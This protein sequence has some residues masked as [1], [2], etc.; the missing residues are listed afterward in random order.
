[1]P[2]NMRNDNEC[3]SC[4]GRLTLSGLCPRC[5]LEPNDPPQLEENE[6]L[7]SSDVPSAGAKIRYF[8]EYELLKEIGQSGG[9]GLVYRARQSTTGRIVALKLL[10]PECLRSEELVQRFRIEVKAAIELDH[11][12]IVPIYEIGENRGQHYYTMK[13]VEEGS[14]AEQMEE[15]KWKLVE[16]GSLAEQ[17]DEGKWNLTSPQRQREL[18]QL[19]EQVARGVS[20]AHVHGVLHRDLKPG[21]ILIDAAG[22]PYVA[23][24]GL[25]KFLDRETTATKKNKDVLGSPGYMSPEQADGKL[26]SVTTASDVYSLGVILY[27]LL[28]G[29][30]PF[31]GE[32]LETLRKVREETPVTPRSLNPL[33]NPDLQAICLKCLEKDTRDRFATAQDLAN[34][35]RRFVK[36][37]PITTR[38]PTAWKRLLMWYRREPVVAGLATATAAIFLTGFLLTLWQWSR[39][40]KLA[41][42]ESHA[43]SKAENALAIVNMKT[44]E[45]L[46][47]SG[48]DD[49]AIAI[50]SDLV[51]RD[52][53]N[54]MAA[55]RLLWALNDRPSLCLPLAILKHNDQPRWPVPVSHD[56]R[57]NTPPL[58]VETN[59][60][61]AQTITWTDG[62]AGIRTDVDAKAA[63]KM[64]DVVRLPRVLGT[65]QSPVSKS[66]NP[67]FTGSPVSDPEDGLN[68]VIVAFSSDGGRFAS[69]SG[70]TTVRVWDVK[71]GEPLAGPLVHQG[72]VRALEFSA[73]GQRLLTTSDQDPQSLREI[74]KENSVQVWDVL[75]G[76]LLNHR[77]NVTTASFSPDGR[78]VLTVSG[79]AARV[80]DPETGQD[81]VE[82][83]RHDSNV[84][85]AAF[86]PDGQ[87]IATGSDDATARIWNV[88]T[89]Q[90]LSSPIQ[91]DSKSS[92]WLVA[93][94][95]DS[96]RLVTIANEAARVWE[97]GTGRP[98]T[99]PLEHND[100]VE[101][102]SFSPDGTGV[103]TLTRHTGAVDDEIGVHIWDANNGRLCDNPL[104]LE[105]TGAFRSAEFEPGTQDLVI[106]SEGGLDVIDVARGIPAAEPLSWKPRGSVVACRSSGGHRVIATLAGGESLHNG[107]AVVLWGI[108][109]R[110]RCLDLRGEALAFSPDGHRVVTTWSPQLWDI[111]TGSPLS[112]LFPLRVNYSFAAFSRDGSKIVTFGSSHSV[113]GRARRLGTND[114]A[115]LCAL[116]A[117]GTNCQIWEANRGRLLGQYAGETNTESLSA[118]SP[119]VQRFLPPDDGHI[120]IRDFQ[121]GHYLKWDLAPIK[122][123]NW[124]LLRG[125]FS[126]NG[127]KVLFAEGLEQVVICDV[128]G[129]IK[130]SHLWAIQ[131]QPL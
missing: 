53:T 84:L 46:F 67:V 15:G 110:E 21:N 89:G 95:P 98:L 35:L 105:N 26:S 82:P 92:V 41:T 127:K 40:N 113:I 13:L 129:R 86:S 33:V 81:L 47:A 88:L 28:T 74:S 71:T 104:I 22:H 91:H 79:A 85:T 7:S 14:L 51:R 109:A 64:S 114:T 17:M 118:F 123:T 8:G 1:M 50:L 48:E 90:P 120:L 42:K 97:V 32:S 29:Q 115:P 43:R 68:P 99:E 25:A 101:Y 4:G 6:N 36:S 9:M 125:C 5:V 19:M 45:K 100:P 34:E 96:Q 2:E 76:H 49:R 39:A 3:P 24:F 27:E 73:D 128:T 119:N 57:S 130:T 112:K 10:K 83:M 122:T 117:R 38:R 56:L 61:P 78:R 12:N 106:M 66:C 30:P 111:N 70:P 44:V 80:W 126:P 107:A 52:P 31:Q 72:L 87:R 108:S 102:V 65:G 18:A 121:D 94:S 116:W 60:T 63:F 20:Y 93:F 23:D 77:S 58:L 59:T 131:N 54:R 124:N 62:V 75:S 16:E 103:V 55:E 37:E 69:I 11:P